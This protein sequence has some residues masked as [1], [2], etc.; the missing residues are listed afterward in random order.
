MVPTLTVKFRPKT[1]ILA[2]IESR[3]N[4][5][6]NISGFFLTD[7]TVNPAGTPYGLERLRLLSLW[8]F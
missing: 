5:R 3:F 4:A 7:N 8:Q 6:D 1:P 2:S